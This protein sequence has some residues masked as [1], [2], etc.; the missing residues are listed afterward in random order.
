MVFVYVCFHSFELR[1]K[2]KI[3]FFTFRIVGRECLKICVNAIQFELKRDSQAFKLLDSNVDEVCDFLEF[4]DV[5]QNS[6]FGAE[7]KAALSSP[8]AC[9]SM[10]KF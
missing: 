3:K 7:S 9:A 10:V 4:L 8:F 6:P 2:R 1:L 5:L